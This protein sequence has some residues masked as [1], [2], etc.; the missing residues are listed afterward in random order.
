[1]AFPRLERDVSGVASE[2]ATLLFAGLASVSSYNSHATELET[3]IEEPGI[4][5]LPRV[6]GFCP[7]RN[8]L[9]VNF[10]TMMQRTP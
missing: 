2:L 3:P 4:L 6:V 5:R 10:G 8:T 7:S 1:M 9:R